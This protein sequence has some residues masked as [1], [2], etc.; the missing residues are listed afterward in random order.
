MESE[1]G[2]GAGIEAPA[3][4]PFKETSNS[5]FDQTG[6]DPLAETG[7]AAELPVVDREG[8]LISQ[9]SGD[10]DETTQVAA[11][12]ESEPES[13]DEAEMRARA[14]AELAAQAEPIAEEPTDAELAA[15]GVP[16]PGA[17]EPV[18]AADPQPA[19]APVSSATPNAE[20]AQPS[21]AAEAANAPATSQD[22][23][24]PTT[25]SATQ[26]SAVADDRVGEATDELE[27]VEAPPSNVAPVPEEKKNE[28]G[29][30]THRRYVLLLP[31]G[32]GKHKEVS[33]WEKDGK[34]VKKGTAGAKKQS[35]CLALGQEEALGVGYRAMGEPE[36]GVGL[37]A[38]SLTY[39]GD[40]VHVEPDDK[41]VRQK[42][43][44]RK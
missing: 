9:P 2:F 22:D 39:W 28:K 16:V 15:A 31:E 24:G 17:E 27:A 34:M 37:R 43:S 32:N 10:A 7:E 25:A 18:A 36:G 23:S 26:E 1:N 44:F 3:D 20:T 5:E 14:E 21:P 13:L 8:E 30:V 42:L 38:V 19:D 4:D 29:V 41:P 12:E 33:W 6:D 11:S 35:V 40:V